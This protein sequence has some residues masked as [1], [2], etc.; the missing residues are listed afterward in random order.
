MPFFAAPVCLSH[1]SS[2]STSLIRQVS[3]IPYLS[4]SVSSI[5]NRKD[6]SRKGSPLSQT[7]FCCASRPACGGSKTVRR[8]CGPWRP[9][10]RVCTHCSET[11]ESPTIPPVCKAEVQP[12]STSWT[13]FEAYLVPLEGRRGPLPFDFSI[14]KVYMKNNLASLFN[15]CETSFQSQEKNNSIRKD[16]INSQTF[17]SIC[18]Q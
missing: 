8:P 1:I 4:W 18:F 15:N 17:E 5:L 10:P 13:S 14:M 11:A 2:S 6:P 12:A 9:L 16:K 3:S 7:N